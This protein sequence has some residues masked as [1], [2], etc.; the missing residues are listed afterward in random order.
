MTKWELFQGCKDGN[1]C[2]SINMINHINT[3]KDK[4]HIIISR[5][6]EKA[7]DTMQHPFMIKNFNVGIEGT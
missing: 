1:I 6:T 5:D 3:T 2:K 7:F 4:H